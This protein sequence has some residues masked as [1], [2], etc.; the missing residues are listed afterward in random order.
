MLTSR[1]STLDVTKTVPPLTQAKQI[2]DARRKE[3]QLILENLFEREE[4]TVKLVIDCLFDM[5]AVYVIN[6]KIPTPIVNPLVKGVARVSRSGIRIIAF[7][8]VMKKFVLSGF[9]TNF[10]FNKVKG[11]IG[12]NPP[13]KKKKKKNAK[14]LKNKPALSK[15]E[16]SLTPPSQTLAI[17]PYPQLTPENQEAFN[18][19]IKGLA[20]VIHQESN[21]QQLTLTQVEDII[22]QQT[23]Q[24]MLVH[25]KEGQN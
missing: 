5:G 19:H 2:E 6:R 13:A 8:Y 1:P 17:A 22:R 15:K 9:L 4:D 12:A 7:R 25:N 14:P 24:S 20:K 21:S 18:H 11:L 3:V 23:L 10:L 16:D